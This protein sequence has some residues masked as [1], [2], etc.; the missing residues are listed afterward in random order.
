MIIGLFFEICLD[1][2]FPV[3]AE[4]LK[5]MLTIIR[6]YINYFESFK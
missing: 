3:Q 2:K 1:V 5:K 4:I 6:N